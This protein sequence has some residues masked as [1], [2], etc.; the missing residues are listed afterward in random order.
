MTSADA[1]AVAGLEQSARDRADLAL[2]SFDHAIALDP[3]HLVAHQGRAS[4]LMALGSYVAA[5]AE[6]RDVLIAR[7]ASRW[8]PERRPQEVAQGGEIFALTSAVKLRHDR[9]QIRHLAAEGLLPEGAERLERAYGDV[10][11]EIEGAGNRVMRLTDTQRRHIGAG[12]NRVVYLDP[13]LRVSSGVIADGW[14]R[15]AAAER[16]ASDRIAVVDSLLTPDALSAL[17]RYCMDST[18]WFDSSHAQGGRGYIGADGMDGFACPLLFQIAEDL[19]RALPTVIG[20][21]PLIKLWAF[22]YDHA[23]Q[24]INAHAD[25]AQVNVNFWITPDDACLDASA[26]GMIV[27]DAHVP[28]EWGFETFNADPGGLHRHIQSVGGKATNVPYRQNR[29]VIFDSDL[30]HATAP[31]RFRSGYANRRIN[32]TLLYGRR[33]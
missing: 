11:A 9:E 14:D 4:A 33:R 17:R 10:L 23:L 18:I 28:S 2:E 8:W 24:G 7:H 27:H 25:A 26:G 1:H 20:A 12:Y 22:K 21:L 13:G 3:G 16:F 29:A 19:R 6:S 30:I 31:I 15:S 5:V 32:V